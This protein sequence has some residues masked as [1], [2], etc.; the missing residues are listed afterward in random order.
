MT[1]LHLP[2]YE[3]QFL[4]AVYKEMNDYSGLDINFI[5]NIC[6]IAELD[7]DA[8]EL[9]GKWFQ[10]QNTQERKHYEELMTSILI[11]YKVL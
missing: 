10:S 2:E 1:K 4:D 5:S 7:D 11:M 6:E 9:L 8:F 3:E